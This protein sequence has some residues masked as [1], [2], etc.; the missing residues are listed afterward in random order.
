MTSEIPLSDFSNHMGSVVSWQGGTGA[1][2]DREREREEEAEWERSLPFQLPVLAPSSSSEQ[3]SNWSLKVSEIKSWPTRMMNP[4]PPPTIP[5]R[6]KYTVIPEYDIPLS[7]IL[8][9]KH[10]SPLSLREF[11]EYLLYLERSAEN[12]YFHL[13]IQQYSLAYDSW[14]DRQPVDLDSPNSST[15]DIHLESRRPSVPLARSFQRARQLFFDP[16]SQYELNLT[17]DAIDPIRHFLKPASGKACKRRKEAWEE[18][19]GSDEE[20]DA[21]FYS[22]EQN[23]TQYPRPRDLERIKN[24]VEGMLKQSL[25]RFLQLAFTNSGR[26]HDKLGY[27]IS[28]IYILAATAASVAIILNRRPRALRLVV[29]PMLLIAWSVLFSVLNGICPAIFMFGDARQLRPYEIFV[30]RCRMNCRE[31]NTATD[32]RRMGGAIGTNSADPII[33]ARINYR[34]GRAQGKT[35][36]ALAME[37]VRRILPVP[38]SKKRPLKDLEGGLSSSRPQ[39]GDFGFRVEPELE[40]GTSKKGSGETF[41]ITSDSYYADDTPTPT[42]TSPAPAYIPNAS[43]SQL[44]KCKS[45]HR[46][47]PTPTSS[48]FGGFDL[49]ALSPQPNRARRAASLPTPPESESEFEYMDDVMFAREMDLELRDP[50]A[51]SLYG[52]MVN[53]PSAIVRRAHWEIFSRSMWMAVGVTAPMMVILLVIPV[54]SS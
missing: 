19:S 43:P 40:Y 30:L 21:G 31:R 27:T 8:Q 44:R 18:G 54:P 20:G 22:A 5:R 16:A 42:L 35:R 10:A 48:A 33:P 41:D 39:P 4:P 2:K 49:S 12:L 51:L 1:R 3:P 37:K 52:P 7:D 46:H 38:A 14:D 32:Y 28:S 29:A 11:E 26:A 9:D 17:A 36:T 34:R 6:K 53:V 25:T 24:E 13:W 50:R 15:F 23:S 47:P 45:F